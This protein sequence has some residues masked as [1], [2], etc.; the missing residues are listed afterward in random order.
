M[1]TWL[2]D[3]AGTAR[4]CTGAN[5]CGVNPA[6]GDLPAQAVRAVSSVAAVSARRRSVEAYTKRVLLEGR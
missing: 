2:V 4:A 3:G 1:W 6:L 5:A